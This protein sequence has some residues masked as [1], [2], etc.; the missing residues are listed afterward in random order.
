[1]NGILGMAELALATKLTPQQQNYLRIV[2]QSGDS[3]L[4]LLNDVLDL[5]KI[6]AG[7]MELEHIPF[8][9]QQV[10]GD[11]TRLLSAN[12]YKKGLELVCRVA[13][14]APTHVVGD[15]VR[16]RQIIVN[17]V[18]NA[19]KFTDRGDIFVN[20]EVE[21]D[22]NEVATLHFSVRDTGIGIPADKQ[23]AVFEAFQ[24]SDSSTTR[25][26]GGTGLGLSISV[27]FVKLM[28]GRIWL[29][30]LEGEGTT[31]HFC[32]PLQIAEKATSE[33]A[34]NLMG[35]VPALVVSTNP[36]NLHVYSEVLES[37]GAQVTQFSD[38]A[39]AREWIES[40]AQG[41]GLALLDISKADPAALELEPLLAKNGNWIPIALMPPDW[42][43]EG[44][45]PR[46][47]RRLV[48]PVTQADLLA[49][50]AEAFQFPSDS[51]PTDI[52]ANDP[53]ASLSIL[54][55]DDSL[56]NRE[57]AVGLLELQGHRVVAVTNGQEAVEA[58]AAGE[59]DV[60]L[61][62]VEMPVMDGLEAARR[63][64]EREEQQGGRTPIIAMTA[65]A[66]QAIREKCTDA[67]MDSY[68]T[69]PIQP[70]ELFRVLAEVVLQRQEAAP[71][72]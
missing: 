36:T 66:L 65:H 43:D 14:Q 45:A 33:T 61:M 55:A 20:V 12:A 21:A 41:E 22:D 62:D 2:K 23:A 63:I 69:K 40:H 64:R 31:F 8:D 46:G 50:V 25:K 72:H 24:Q 19:V 1:M 57:V 18:G 49:A 53:F 34:S 7:K 56:V 60:V 17:L 51:E 38:H 13:P 30:S 39:T 4:T 11:A 9:L 58:L 28:Q 26:F 71:A 52:V 54:L 47:E 15:P 29:D 16:L 35:G 6:E 67:G 27:Q 48:K 3:L 32:V 10:V 70:D 44:G 37:L 68:I 42:V 59:F 5:S